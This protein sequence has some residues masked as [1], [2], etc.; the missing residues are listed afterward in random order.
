MVVLGVPMRTLANWPG[1]SA[2][3]YVVEH[4]A[5]RTVPLFAF[6][7]V[8]HELQ[9]AMARRPP[10]AAVSRSTGMALSLRASR[11]GR[12]ILQRARDYLLIGIEARVDRAH[13]DERGEAPERPGPRRP[14]LPTG[15]L[16]PADAPGDRGAHLRIAEAQ[17]R[18]LQRGFGGAQVGFALRAARSRARRDRAARWR[19]VPEALRAVALALCV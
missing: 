5:H 4:G 18:R 11:A 2:P 12:K 1:M 13:G 3:S 9:M 19:F 15:H 14:R 16:E 17:A 8:V 7:L 10:S 6:H